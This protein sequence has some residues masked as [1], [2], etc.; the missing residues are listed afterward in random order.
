M[1]IKNFIIISGLAC[2]CYIAGKCSGITKAGKAFDK[3]IGESKHCTI[4]YDILKNEVRV[5]IEDKEKI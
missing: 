2:G 4:M 1:K 3:I 5:D